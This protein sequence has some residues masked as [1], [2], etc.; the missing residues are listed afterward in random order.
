MLSPSS[1]GITPSPNAGH[2]DGG[3][4]VSVIVEMGFDLGQFKDYSLGTIEHHLFAA[5]TKIEDFVLGRRF[6]TR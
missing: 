3:V 2:S 4:R 6:Q 1:C 5:E